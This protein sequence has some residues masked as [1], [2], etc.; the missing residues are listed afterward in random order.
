MNQ[1]FLNNDTVAV[2]RALLGQ[3]LTY[4]DG[5]TQ[6][7]GLIVETE[8]YLGERDA[9]SHAFKGRRTIRNEALYGPR[10][11]IYVYT[12]RG[13][14]LLNFIT[15]AKNKP[16]G[17]LI[18]GLEPTAGLAQMIQ[19]RHGKTGAELT[20]GPGKLT[21]AINLHTLAYNGQQLGSVPLNLSRQQIQQPQLIRALPRI[22]VPNKGRWTEANLRFVVW[23]NPYVSKMP[24]SAI[25]WQNRGW[26]NEKTNH[27]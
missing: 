14:F 5:H 17:V 3:E 26:Q 9:A 4:S 27:G 24:K 19:N 11:S 8:A 18:R 20:N 12:M 7:Q 15:E 25:D 2:A 13:L 6:Y 21:Q 23:G 1:I 22:G 16:R 10:G